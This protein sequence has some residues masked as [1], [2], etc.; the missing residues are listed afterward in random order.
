M[1]ELLSWL[2]SH[3]WAKCYCVRFFIGTHGRR[4]ISNL[5]TSNIFDSASGCERRKAMPTSSRPD[6]HED[7]SKNLLKGDDDNSPERDSRSRRKS[8]SRDNKDRKHKRRRSKDKRKR[9]RRRHYSSS[10]SDDSSSCSSEDSSSYHRRDHKRKEDR[11]KKRKKKSSSKR[12]RRLE[13]VDSKEGS[14]S[15]A[16]KVESNESNL[17]PMHPPA[18]VAEAPPVAVDPPQNEKPNKKRA[19]M[20]PMS[21][22]EYDKQQS[23]VRQVY[24][25]E[26]GRY[27]M[28]R[29]T[30][31]IIE[32]IV[33]R[34]DHQR[35]NQQATRGDG[36]SF[37]RSTLAVAAKRNYPR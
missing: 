7:L 35:I 22:A 9:K 34:A 24:D 5:L 10:S 8:Y 29:G 33:S 3:R 26:T 16:P 21:K 37:S 6:D 13:R 11:H 36:A 19:M 31:E 1:E 25:E 20:V 12:R 28:V 2:T 18:K 17:K 15:S 32:S 30:G 4:T 27:R 23:Q 14:A